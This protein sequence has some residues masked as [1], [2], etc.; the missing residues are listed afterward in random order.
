MLVSRGTASTSTGPEGTTQTQT[1]GMGAL[2]CGTARAA[3]DAFDAAGNRSSQATSTVTTAA[4][5]DLQP[6]SVPTGFKQVA[7]TETTVL[8]SWAPSTDDVGVVG[9][10]LYVGGLR[11]GTVSEASAALDRLTCGSSIESASTRTTRLETDPL[12]SIVVWTAGCPD[13]EPPTAP[14]NVTVSSA[15]SSSVTLAWSPATDNVGV[16]EYRIYRGGSRVSS[17]TGP[18]GTVSGL[19]CGTS[20][21]V[22]VDAA[23][24]AA[25]RSSRSPR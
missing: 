22:R 17:V 19:T 18:G 24:A 12:G 20:Y 2:T 4:C 15:T 9:Y 21:T 14:S 10:G 3:V 23:D 7:T 11:V 8:L 1:F 16:S 13:V 6:P 5:L 25:N